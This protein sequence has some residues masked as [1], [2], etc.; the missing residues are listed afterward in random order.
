MCTFS[1]HHSIA[2]PNL[3]RGVGDTTIGSAVD[4]CRNIKT[5]IVQLAVADIRIHKG[6]NSSV[7]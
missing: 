2:R 6:V 5:L 4:L 3:Y 7:V 1:I